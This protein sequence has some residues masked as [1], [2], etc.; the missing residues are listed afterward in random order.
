M[1]LKQF[2]TEGNSLEKK[3]LCCDICSKN[4]KCTD[5]CQRINELPQVF[6]HLL[7]VLKDNTVECKKPNISDIDKAYLSKELE[8]LRTNILK[9]YD[10][11]VSGKGIC[12]GFPI[13]AVSEVISISHKNLT[14][15]E[16]LLNTS[17]VN[18]DIIVSVLDT[19]KR[20]LN[21]NNDDGKKH[22]YIIEHKMDY[23]YESESEESEDDIDFNRYRA[24]LQIDSDSG[25]DL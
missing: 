9:K 21:Q 24:T 16:I 14:Y 18:N 6:M 22:G 20:L 15:E 3:H 1:L 4:C 25:S 8:L 10:N 2:T 12:S 23:D 19:V 17:I 5:D 13:T 7:D 11:T